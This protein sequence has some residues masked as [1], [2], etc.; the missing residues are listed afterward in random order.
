MLGW[1]QFER[2]L[3]EVAC[4]SFGETVPVDSKVRML[5]L[6]AKPYVETQYGVVLVTD[7]RPR[8]KRESQQSQSSLKIDF[9]ISAAMQAAKTLAETSFSLPP[10]KFQSPE[11]TP[12]H[13]AD[14]KLKFREAG[15]KSSET[16]RKSPERSQSPSRIVRTA[17]HSLS[18]ASFSDLSVV[19]SASFEADKVKVRLKN[20]FRKSSHVSL[21]ERH[22]SFI[23]KSQ[24]KNFS[25]VSPS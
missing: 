1:T 17:V 14:S 3:F 25:T 13:A 10:S 11:R 20:P 5:M 22:R 8:K 7:R 19:R 2:F 24:Q 9:N 4:V 23:E 15:R 18:A 16:D 6:Q 21:L 12:I